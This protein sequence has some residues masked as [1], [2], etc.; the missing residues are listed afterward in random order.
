VSSADAGGSTDHAQILDRGYRRF[1]GTR[2]GVPGAMRSVA[3]HTTRSVLGLGR[4]ARHKVAPIIVLVI[5]FL[6][7]VVFV[8]ISALIGD[9]IFTD[10]FVPEFWELPRSGTTIAAIV[11]FTG[12][13]APEALVRDR[14]D[15]MLSMYLSTPLT[16]VTYL[17]SKLLSVVGILAL[18]VVGPTLMYLLGLTFASA[19]PDGFGNWFEIFARVLLSGLAVSVVYSLISMAAS[20]VTDRRAFASVSV[21]MVMLGL[22]TVVQ[23]LIDS[24]DAGVNWRLLDPIN[25]P[26]E[27]IARVFGAAGEYPQIATERIYGANVGWAVVSCA[28]IWSRYRKAGA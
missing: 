17:L 9:E 2:S 20:S 12:L 18:I 26:L 19:G 14:R 10:G 28:V 15:G 11:L 25:L 24:A 1:E 7:A 5:A 27:M 6:P 21:V 16:R 4:L 13:V 22:L 8:G 3:W 23:I